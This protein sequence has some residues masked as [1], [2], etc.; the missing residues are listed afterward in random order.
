MTAEWYKI[1]YIAKPCDS[2]YEFYTQ[3][4]VEYVESARKRNL[5]W[6]DKRATQS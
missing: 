5:I 6:T 1:F 2:M 3:Q 4:I